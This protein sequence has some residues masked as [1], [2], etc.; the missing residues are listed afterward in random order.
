MALIAAVALHVTDMDAS[1]EFWV[2]TLG[3]RKAMDTGLTDEAPIFGPSGMSDASAVRICALID[4]DVSEDAPMSEQPPGIL[5]MQFEG[6]DRNPVQA[7][8][9]DPGTMH[10]AVQVKDFEARVA[11][12]QAAGHEL[13]GPV[14][15]SLMGTRLGMFTDPDG[16]TLEL[17]G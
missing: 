6:I 7:R 9:Q 14:G 8:F 5:L 12:F 10:I 2:D 13:L 17:L 16:F 11:Q 4:A 1:L 3:M 15:P